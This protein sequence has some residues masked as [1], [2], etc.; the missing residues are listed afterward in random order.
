MPETLDVSTMHGQLQE[1]LATRP[2][3]LYE[4]TQFARSEGGYR[5]QPANARVLRESGWLGEDDELTEE[6]RALVRLAVQGESLADL[7]VLGLVELTAAALL[8][9]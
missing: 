8:T 7:H 1:F 4:L 3:L 9:S 5:I 2:G 6:R